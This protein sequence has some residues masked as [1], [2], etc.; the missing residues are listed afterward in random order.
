MMRYTASIAARCA[1]RQLKM[2]EFSEMDKSHVR[3]EAPLGAR[4]ES[5]SPLPASR[6]LP[7]AGD[8]TRWSGSAPSNRADPALDVRVFPFAVRQRVD[9]VAAVQAAFTRIAGPGNRVQSI[10]RIRL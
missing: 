4:W 7:D 3:C 6:P 8:H 9:F 10:V 2:D 5:I 1:A